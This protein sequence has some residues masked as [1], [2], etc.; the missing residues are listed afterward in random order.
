M[1]D[2]GPAVFLSYASQDAEAVRKICDALRTAGIEVW[3]DQAELVGGDAWDQKIRGQIKSCA[4]FVPVISTATNARREGYFRREWKLAVDRTHDMDEALP[5]LLPVVIDG[6]TDAGA[7]VPE[8]FREVQWTRLPGGETPPAFCQ[9]VQALLTGGTPP[10]VARQASSPPISASPPLRAKRGLPTWAWLLLALPALAVAYFIFKPRRSPEEI[11]RLIANAQI[12]AEKA[13]AQALAARPTPVASEAAQLAER[14]YALTQKYSFT[15]GELATAESLAQRATELEPDLPRAWA[16]RAWVQ[17]AYLMRNWDYSS[18]RMQDTQTFASHALSLRAED[19]DALNALGQVLE[20]QGAYQEQ[21]QIARRAM[22]SD[23]RNM[24]S[25]LT[26]AR[27]LIWL[28]RLD[29]ARS[30]LHEAVALDPNNP[31]RHYEL[32]NTY[33]GFGFGV[34]PS[35]ESDVTNA[36]AE[37]DAALALQPF[38]SAILAKAGILAGRRGDL[39]GMRATLD[40]LDALPLE[41]RSGERAVFVAML[42]GLLE[43]KPSR[44]FAAAALTASTYFEDATIESPKAWGTALAYHIDGKE[45]SAQQE[46]QSAE[47]TLRERLRNVPQDQ[48]L[49]AELATTLAWENRGDDADRLIQ[50][51]EAAWR[52][53]MAPREVT[54]LARYYAARGDA[55]KAAFYLRSAVGRSN[56]V[57]SHMLALDPWWDKLRGD[58]EFDALA[59]KAT[60]TQ[61]PPAPDSPAGAVKSPPPAA[62]SNPQLERA[63]QII[64]A[65]DVIATDLAVAED[66]VKAVLAAHPT[67]VEGTLLMGRIQTYYLVRGYDRSEER[68]ALAR[69]MAERGQT[70]APDHP[71]ALA[72]MGTYL[73]RRGTELPRAAKLLRRAIEL[74][75]NEPRHYRMLDN[76]LSV[77]PGVTDAEVIAAAT[78][79][80]ERFPNDAVVQYEAARHYRDAGQLE[81]ALL[82]LERAIQQG[83]VINALI[84]H[85]ELKLAVNGDP[86]ELDQLEDKL[87]ERY[88]STARAVYAQFIRAC[89]SN[90]PELGLEA[91]RRMPEPWIIDF[92]Y[93]GPTNLLVGELLLLQGKPELAQLKFAEAQTELAKHPVDLQRNFSTTWL[94]PWILM[95]LEK[96]ADAR[97]RNAVVF[98]ELERPYRVFLG[99]NWWFSAIPRNLLLGERDKALTLIRE[100]SRFDLGPQVIRQGLRMDPRLAAWRNDPEIL[101]LLEP[102]SAEKK[103]SRPSSGKSAL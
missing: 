25:R 13:T 36:L 68:F 87:P 32:A 103:G 69:Q 23:P 38:T 20:K 59:A 21:E 7:F 57:T 100:A 58:P 50:P 89:A 45:N 14:A 51:I 2:S 75:P 88:Q 90:R 101:K 55:A 26:L 94:E 83:P 47:A 30:V 40:R 93:T 8:K 54:I 96:I 74:Q 11:S 65:I 61:R 92:D 84:G 86:T 80:A 41:E 43:K 82:Y 81:P 39:A 24:R 78:R 62:L 67:D 12:L 6:T 70:L 19:A 48:T 95:R 9:R 53:G 4:L 1:A 15:R 17:A 64:D 77:M 102:S 27:A 60:F 97:A 31:L 35:S 99:T 44:V 46:W 37:L 79:T 10:V 3:F 98:S 85:A 5:F 33:A 16:V 22:A 73:Y 42:A 66:L 49:Q 56:F 63:R 76:I 91:L 52:E 71:D 18:K 72:N 28:G 34:Q 29:E